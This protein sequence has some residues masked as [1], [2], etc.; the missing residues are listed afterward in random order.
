M[1]LFHTG[2]LFVE[3]RTPS[4]GVRGATPCGRY[5]LPADVLKKPFRFAGEVV[6]IQR[7]DVGDR[8]RNE[9]NFLLLDARSA[10]TSWINQTQQFAW[11]FEEVLK[12]DGV[13]QDFLLFA[14]VLSGLSLQASP[15]VSGAGWWGLD[16]PCDSNEGV[17]MSVDAWHDDR[18]DLE[19]STACFASRIKRIRKDLGH[20]SWL[21]AAAAYITATKT[22]AERE[23][24]WKSQSFWDIPLP[25][26]AEEL[27][28][29][30]IA[31]AIIFA[32]L[33]DYGL[34]AAGT[35]PLIFDNVTG[36][37]LAKDLPVAEIARM[38][39]TPPRK[40]LEL[41]P[42]LKPSV[43]KFPAKVKGR[44]MTH[45]IHTPRGKGWVLVNKL[46]AAGYLAQK[47]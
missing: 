7:P 14:P 37:A 44:N 9:L 3:A 1:L 33:R 4:P 29:R 26:N 27:V 6:P 8:I 38:T 10:L 22:V 16:K 20:E 34:N 24:Q 2:C 40:I 5:S 23:K 12:R 25:D 35:P 31:F 17:A 32:H 13:P 41:N 30:W 15:R 36:I 46:K 39:D 43:G 21:M 45:S 47:P 19:L 42:K 11:I 28:V 18:L